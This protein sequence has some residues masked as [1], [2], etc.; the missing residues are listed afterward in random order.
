MS[1][2]GQASV[3]STHLDDLLSKDDVSLLEVM[4]ESEVLQE[5]KSQ[6]KKLVD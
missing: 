4:G 2:W 5:C 1:Y 3:S 6:N